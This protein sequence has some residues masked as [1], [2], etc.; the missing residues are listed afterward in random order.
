MSLN[1]SFTGE[2]NQFFEEY[3]AA[4]LGFNCQI[5]KNVHSKEQI[6]QTKKIHDQYVQLKNKADGSWENFLKDMPP[7]ERHLF[8]RRLTRTLSS[9]N[10]TLLSNENLPFFE[11]Q[12]F[13]TLLPQKF[14]DIVLFV[15][16]SVEFKNPDHG[17]YYFCNT[18]ITIQKYLKGS[19]QT[20]TILSPSIEEAGKAYF[21]TKEY[22]LEKNV[23]RT[24]RMDII[25]QSAKKTR[26]LFS[27]LK[28]KRDP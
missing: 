11:F 13:F 24:H 27:N 9:Q 23:A 15:E 1:I 25:S 22:R 10:F 7:F 28:K 14:V 20:V 6:A 2:A 3:C 8:E 12:D 21:A 19:A 5:I 18:N 17:V 4:D 26:A 16:E